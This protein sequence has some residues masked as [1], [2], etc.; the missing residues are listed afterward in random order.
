MKKRLNFCWRSGRIINWYGRQLGLF[1]AIFLTSN[2]M[3]NAMSAI[4]KE[5]GFLSPWQTPWP[6][7]E[8]HE[9]KTQLIWLFFYAYVASWLSR[10]RKRHGIWNLEWMKISSKVAKIYVGP[11]GDP[12]V[13]L[14]K[15]WTWS[16]TKFLGLKAGHTKKCI[17]PHNHAKPN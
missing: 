1:V 4:W 11:K 5:R 14:T 6:Y 13:G 15:F 16:W 8:R 2:S 3:V 17:K 12:K 9:C 10:H 7:D